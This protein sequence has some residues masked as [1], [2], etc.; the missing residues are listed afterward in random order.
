VS[1]ADPILVLVSPSRVESHPAEVL[2]VGSQVNTEF[3]YAF[4]PRFRAMLDTRFTPLH[5]GGDVHVATHLMGAIRLAGPL[6]LRLGMGFEAAEVLTQVETRRIAGPGRSTPVTVEQ[7]VTGASLSA[8][9]GLEWPIPLVWDRLAL[10]VTLDA[11][12][13][14]WPIADEA[15]KV[16]DDLGLIGA[17]LGMAVRFY[18]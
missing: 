18:P 3:G 17:Q 15:A 8:L 12:V 16:F 4:G 13:A 7:Q 1:S 6:A 14:S 2:V 11:V 5:T 10:A 9:V